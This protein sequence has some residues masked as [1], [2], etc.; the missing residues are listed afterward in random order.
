MRSE[1]FVSLVVLSRWELLWA[2][3]VVMVTIGGLGYIPIVHLVVS[4]D[5]E[6]ASSDTMIVEE[7]VTLEESISKWV[8]TWLT[9]D[10]FSGTYDSKV[11][12]LGLSLKF[13][14]TCS[15]SLKRMIC[16]AIVRTD[17]GLLIRI[18]G[19]RAEPWMFSNFIGTRPLTEFI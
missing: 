8:H 1:K 13:E 19:P 5:L 11:W 3:L 18:F 12:V 2:I 15:K 9:K 4:L 7:Y 17:L 10:N 16:L 6:L 14:S